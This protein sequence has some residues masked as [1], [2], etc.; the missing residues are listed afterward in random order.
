MAPLLQ[1]ALGLAPF[2]TRTSALRAVFYNG[3]STCGVDHAPKD[4]PLG[5]VDLD[6]GGDDESAETATCHPIAISKMPEYSEAQYCRFYDGTT[7]QD[8]ND[9]QGA[10]PFE[11]Q[12]FKISWDVTPHEGVSCYLFRS[13]D[14]DSDEHTGTKV[15]LAAEYERYQRVD[16]MRPEQDRMS[17]YGCSPG[18]DKWTGGIFMSFKCYTSSLEGLTLTYRDQ[19]ESIVNEVTAWTSVK[20][21]ADVDLTDGQ[22]FIE[23]KLDDVWYKARADP[24]SEDLDGGEDELKRWMRTLLSDV[25]YLREGSM[26]EGFLVAFHDWQVKNVDGSEDLDVVISE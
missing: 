26:A 1:L 14:C 16:Q 17:I 5:F 9:W 24:A 13:P 15:G 7:M 22:A 23:G 18:N 25:L 12:S 19:L 2:M 6:T 4:G 8:C 20:G 10:A 21:Y 3:T 11:A